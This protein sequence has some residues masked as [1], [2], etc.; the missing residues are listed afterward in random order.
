MEQFPLTRETILFRLALVGTSGRL[1]EI[2]RPDANP[3][4]EWEVC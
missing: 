3:L 4:G 1:E 2:G